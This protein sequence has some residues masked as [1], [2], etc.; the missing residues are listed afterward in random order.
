MRLVTFGR[1]DAL[2][3]T[4]II[5]DSASD[6]LPGTK[7]NLTVIPLSI[8]FGEG[9]AAAIYAD[10]VDISHERFYELLVESDSLPKTS[11]PAPGLF[12]A[13]FEAARDAD[14][15]VVV[16]TLAREFSGTYQSAQLARAE[17]EAD[18]PSYAARIHM[19]DSTNASLGEAAL[20]EWALAMADAGVPALQIFEELEFRKRDLRLVALLDTLEYLRRG[21]RLGAGAAALGTLLSIKPVIEVKDG[22]ITVLGKARGSKNGKNLLD[23][24]IEEVGGVDFELPVSVGF[25][26]VSDSLVKKYVEDSRSLWEGNRE[27]LSAHMIGATIGTHAGPGAIGVA[28]FA[29]R[30]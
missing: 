9:D 7:P 17:I 23:T 18:D 19:V 11:Q 8:T 4:R 6:F 28:F 30:A 26:G 13:A 14:E 15:D 10:G 25:T 2:M 24:K 1:K 21:G 20:V 16:I 3:S 5:T 22:A 29:K 27:A 12:Q